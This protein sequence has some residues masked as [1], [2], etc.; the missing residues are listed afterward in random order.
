VVV[1]TCVFYFFVLFGF[2]LRRLDV[3][4][5]H[6][7]QGL[8]NMKSHLGYCYY[9]CLFVLFGDFGCVP[10]VL[11]LLMVRFFPFPR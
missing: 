10:N 2:E 5:F 6:T 7:S 4:F 11:S 8:S 1:G 9:F 3:S